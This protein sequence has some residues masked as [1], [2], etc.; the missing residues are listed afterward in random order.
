MI[1]QDL[2]AG[3]NFSFIGHL[4]SGQVA[5]PATGLAGQAAASFRRQGLPCLLVL[6]VRLGNEDHYFY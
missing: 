3:H 5:G 1:R 6:G 4:P 2:R